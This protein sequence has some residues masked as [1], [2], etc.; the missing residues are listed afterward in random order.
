MTNWTRGHRLAVGLMLL[1]VAI[2]ALTLALSPLTFVSATP[3]GMLGV[4]L[5]LDALVEQNAV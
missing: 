4:L 2:E 5:F 3:L 1:G